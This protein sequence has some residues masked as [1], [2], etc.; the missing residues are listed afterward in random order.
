LITTGICRNPACSKA[1]A[2]EIV[3]LYP[4]PGE[5]CPECGEALHPEDSGPP[6][7]DAAALPFP[8][9][10]PEAYRDF[11]ARMFSA[12][13]LPKAT[14]FWL[15]RRFF[16]SV[17]AILAAAI[18]YAFLGPVP[19]LG[20]PAGRAIQVCRSS[21]TDR[22]AGDVVSTFASQ[23]GTQASRFELANGGACDVRF[24]AGVAPVG[25]VV[26]HDGVVIVVNPQNPVT[27]LTLTQVRAILTGA[28]T[29]WAELGGTQGPI[30]P[31]APPDGSDETAL[32]AATLLHDGK[33]GSA[34]VRAR[35]SA[36]I[37]RAVA[38][39]SGRAR[40]GVVAFSVA[41]PAKIVKIVSIPPASTLSIAD[42]RY[43]FSL[44]VSVRQE[45]AA[46]DPLVA[47][48]LAYARSDAAQTLVVRD[49]LVTKAGF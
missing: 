39:P 5:Y 47:A 33:L 19:I 13:E 37:V 25:D 1:A 43:P 28:A 16:G 44:S 15:S 14:P 4:G 38:A 29:D 27:E 11:E 31:M 40:I 46:R 48:L 23:N 12:L 42:H 2:A 35:S 36:A 49:G 9:L 10:S 34:V 21:V 3:E 26:A 8:A 17:A 20:R 30:V 45:R 18:G 6:S 7:G 32:L 24:S 41:V 22:L